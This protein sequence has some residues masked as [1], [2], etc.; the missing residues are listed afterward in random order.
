LTPNS[1]YRVQLNRDFDFNK[2][3][4]ILPYLHQLGISHVYASPIFQARTGSTHGYDV[5]DPNKISEELGGQEAFEAVLGEAAALGLGWIQDIVPNHVAYSPETVF[6]AD[7]MKNGAAS[8]FQGFLDVDWNHPSPDLGGKILAPFLNGSFDECV[9]S[10]DVK[11][12]YHDG[13]HIEFGGLEFPVKEDS[14]KIILRE[15]STMAVDET[16]KRVNNDKTL[17]RRLLSEQIYV[18]AHWK[19]ALKEIN[20]RRFFD[21]ADLICLRMEDQEVFDETHRLIKKLLLEK[22][23]C[24]LRVDHIDG[25]F[26]PEA[27]LKR[28]REMG[29]D[30]YVVVEKILLGKEQL[31]DSWKVEGTTG[32]DYVNQLN[33]LFVAAENEAELSAV[34]SDFIG[35]TQ[36]FFKLVCGCKNRLIRDYFGGEMDNLA[37]LFIETAARVGLARDVSAGNVREALVELISA[38]PVYRTYVRGK[39]RTE[40]DSE[41]FF[42]AL[43][44]ANQHN[45]NLSPEFAILQKM[46]ETTNQ[47]NDALRFIMRLQQFT[48]AIMAKGLEDTA[49]YRYNR[50]L[51]LNEVGGDPSRFGVAID[52]FHCFQG[53]RQKTTLN[54][55]ATHD[56]KRGED[57]RARLN[58]LSEI[59]QEF[60]SQ[61]KNWSQLNQKQQKTIG[62][63]RAPDKNEEYYIYQTLLAS[64]S[65]TT[66]E[67]GGYSQR[68]KLHLTKA[69]REA[70][71]NSDWI[72][73]NLA[74]E[75]AISTYVTEL[76][77]PQGAFLSA[78]LPFQKKIAFYGCLNSLSQTLIKTASPGV[79]D[80]YQGTELWDLNLVD[81][82]N[83]RP[84][85]YLKRQGFL[86]ELQS[87]PVAELILNFEDGRVKLFEI[88]RALTLINKNQRLF[89]EGDYIPLTVNGTHERSIVA[90]AR[91]S[92]SDWAVVV[93]PRFLVGVVELEQLPLGE[94]WKDTFVS[95]PQAAPKQWRNQ[96]TGEKA[97]SG[98]DEGFF[99][100][101][102][103]RS[104]PV[105]LLCSEESAP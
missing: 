103:L 40:K 46:F 29:S 79:P 74:Y 72:S 52:E 91:R 94:V 65:S 71:V 43:K 26:D 97:V 23:I 36:D 13:F 12:G 75:E 33:G 78:F 95:L 102:L 38:F 24:G 44:T 4:A 69:L 16:L 35:E 7:L 48:G 53:A 61:I 76:L 83:R 82:D 100:G 64:Y 31:P 21:Q 55:S 81:P 11:L 99:V 92:F 101:D 86:K 54:A 93:A 34:Y 37:R 8:R 6:V 98:S 58:V 89:Q 27:Y 57:C 62:G 3:K 39:G 51:S 56:T 88:N 77:N 1:T 105:A 73:P 67:L 9:E 25:L 80:F 10:G 47:S 19:R 84:V 30:G 90:F 41:H 85:D 28:L 15:G 66:A 32:Y 18:L 45:Q 14:Q 63:K 104:F 87:L 50:L 59:P 70:K 49:L 5:T 96:F 20:Y 17:L 42:G 22:K 60:E 2:L 68:L